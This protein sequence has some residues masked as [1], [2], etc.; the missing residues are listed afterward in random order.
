M[1]QRNAHMG[2][3]CLSQGEDARVHV[4]GGIPNSSQNYS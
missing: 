2:S 3:L 1:Q 4:G